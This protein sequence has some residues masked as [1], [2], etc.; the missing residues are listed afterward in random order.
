MKILSRDKDSE[1]YRVDYF[2]LTESEDAKKAI[3][4]C[5]VCGVKINLREIRGRSSS[6]CPTCKTKDF[7][8]QRQLGEKDV[9]SF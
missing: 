6:K 4:Y 9:G 2:S 7:L 3:I 8:Y 1:R 5:Y